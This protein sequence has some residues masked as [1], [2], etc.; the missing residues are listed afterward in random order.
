H[1]HGAGARR[2]PGRGDHLLRR[3]QAARS[4]RGSRPDDRAARL[5]PD[6]RADPALASAPAPPDAHL[7]ALWP[8]AGR[9]LQ[10]GRRA[11][12]QEGGHGVIA[13]IAHIT[14]YPHQE[15]IQQQASSG[16]GAG[17]AVILAGVIVT[18]L[19]VVAL[20]W[21]KKRTDASAE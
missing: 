9:A 3:E 14:Q 20:V 18:L 12:S 13:L 1:R 11:Q 7:P 16:G 17:V 21:L 15:P 6:R 19:A 10:E 2:R 5:H 4:R 8:E